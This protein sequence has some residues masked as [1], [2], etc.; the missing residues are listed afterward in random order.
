[1]NNRNFKDISEFAYHPHPM[2][3]VDILT[4]EMKELSLELR[5][6]LKYDSVTA[7]REFILDKFNDL[8][9][10]K[11]TL[12]CSDIA[13]AD[14]QSLSFVLMIY[15]DCKSRSMQFAIRNPSEHLQRLLKMTRL[16]TL[17]SVES[18]ASARPQ[19]FNRTPL[20]S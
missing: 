2:L 3:G 15:R 4:A 18:D 19:V 11:L 13:F 8:R 7:L 5:G 16:D 1:M 10:R 9:P 20:N 17:L 6:Q 14:S 12:D